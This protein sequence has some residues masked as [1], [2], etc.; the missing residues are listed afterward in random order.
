MN[1]TMCISDKEYTVI[2]RGLSGTLY[3]LDS[4]TLVKV[5]GD[6]SR[7]ERI[8]E[9]IRLAELANRQGLPVAVPC[10]TVQLGSCLGALYQ[11]PNAVTVDEALRADSSRSEEYGHKMGRLF[12][13][14]HET[15]VGSWNLPMLSD[16][17]TQW[18]DALEKHHLCSE[19]AEQ[20][21]RIAGT[22]PT[23][24][25]L[26]YDDLHEG[27]V[28]VRDNEVML[29]DLDGAC[30][31]PKLYDMA[32]HRALHIPHAERPEGVDFISVSLSPAQVEVMG[33]YTQLEYTDRTLGEGVFSRDSDGWLLPEQLGTFLMDINH[34]LDLLYS[35]RALLFL[36]RAAGSPM[37]TPEHIRTILE[38][39][40]P[41]LRKITAPNSELDQLLTIQ[42]RLRKSEE[43][44]Q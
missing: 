7:R 11:L 34:K 30:A 26:L 33:Y 12:K 39:F 42:E 31:G 20:M 29:I 5:F 9:N 16:K 15:D 19:D 24:S 38:H 40:V 37:L 1:K 23:G 32:A 43:L 10:G 17:V 2:S 36:G 25:S 28:L 44:N 14:L 35:Y 4:D 13:K 22:L 27:N 41:M 8:E 18:I 6:G 21:R 3:R